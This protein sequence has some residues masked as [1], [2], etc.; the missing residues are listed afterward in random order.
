MPLIDQI[1]A[2]IKNCALDISRVNET[3]LFRSEAKTAAIPIWG[4]TPSAPSPLIYFHQALIVIETY[5]HSEDFLDWC[6]EYGWSPS[7]PEKL[8][9][10]KAIGDGRAELANLIGSDQLDTLILGLSVHQAI[11][12]ARPA[13]QEHLSD[14]E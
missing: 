10:F 3:I 4:K 5:D 6:K 9:R 14:N 12:T 1:K 13:S 11:E 2:C 7:E 8:E